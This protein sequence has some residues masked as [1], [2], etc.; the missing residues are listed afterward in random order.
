M[1]GWGGEGVIEICVFLCEGAGGGGSK[2]R[3]TEVGAIDCG[4]SAYFLAVQLRVAV[5]GGGAAASEGVSQRS[6]ELFA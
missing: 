4:G 6:D 2:G 5:G 1:C 3:G